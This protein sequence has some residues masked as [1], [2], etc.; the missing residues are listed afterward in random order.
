[1]HFMKNHILIF[2]HDRSFTGSTV[3]LIYILQ[4]LIADGFKITVCTTK[5]VEDASEYEKLGCGV[6]IL[7]R[8]NVLNIHHNNSE[9]IFSL[10]GLYGLILLIFRF[11]HGFFDSKRIINKLK[12]DLVYLNEYVLFQYGFGAKSLGIPVITHI[13]SNFI[14]KK[15]FLRHAITQKAIIYAS[16]K[17]I[18]ITP[19]DANQFGEQPI[20]TIVYEF[21]NKDNFIEFDSDKIKQKYA[22][23]DDKL[24]FTFLGG[25]APYKGTYTL[26][27]AAEIALNTTDSVAFL[28]AGT[29]VKNTDINKLYYDE[30]MQLL[31]NSEFKASIRYI[32]R[33]EN[34]VEFIACGDCLVSANT[35][36]HFSRPAIE[37]WAQKKA[38]IISDV[39]HCREIFINNE[40]ALLFEPD[41]E[42]E[43][44]EK[45]ELFSRKKDL[46]NRLASKGFAKANE[47]FSADAN[48]SKISSICKSLIKSKL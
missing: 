6:E 17:I 37:A 25:I 2:D 45:I 14:K 13:R 1:M 10:R 26:L 7:R 39:E 48:I 24:V 34:P 41:N 19:A 23:P 42:I 44:A 36:S 22:I 20:V 8:Y 4:G 27:K 31:G 21:L 46:L 30:C 16:N 33:V 28:I 29:A 43:L 35:I 47:L 12:P 9:T 38:V 15:Y 11:I 3:S 5:T 40:N 32:G 18:A